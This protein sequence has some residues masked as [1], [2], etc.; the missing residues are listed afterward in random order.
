MPIYTCPMHPQV[1]QNKPGFCPICGMSLESAG[2]E[3]NFELKDMTRRFW[4]AVLLTIPIFVL[5]MVT[6]LRVYGLIQLALATPVVFYC[7]SFFFR[8]GIKS[9][10]MFTLI[11]L[12]VLVAYI[13]SAVAVLFPG[14]FPDSFRQGG[15]G[16]YFEAAAVITVLVILGQILE[17]RARAKTS[18]AIKDLL[19]LSPEMATV[20]VDRSEKKVALA[21]VKVGDILRVRPG[22]KVPVDGKIVEGSSVVDESMI[23]GESLPVEKEMGAKVTGATLNG[24]GSFLMRADKVGN[25]TLLA[26]IVQMVSEAQGSRAPIQKLVDKIASWFVPIIILVALITFVVWWM[27]GPSFAY[28]LI[29]A[30]SVLIIACPCALGLATPM[31]IMVG[32]GKG[33]GMGILIK[34]AEA[35][36]QMA[37][38][39][40]VVV[41][42]TGTLTEGKVRLNQ[43]FAE[44]P[45]SENELLELVASLEQVSEHPLS[46]AIV[47]KAKERGLTLQKT[48]NFKSFTGKGI[49]GEVSGKKLAIGNPKLMQELGI[50]LNQQEV[51]GQ[52]VLYVAINQAPAGFLALSDTVKASSYEAIEQLHAQKIDVVMLTGD[53]QSTA[54]AIGKELKID[55]IESE[56]LP[57]DKNRIVK[58][59]Q[60]QG[61]IVAMAGDGINDA[62]ALAAADIGIAMGTGT[63]VALESAPITLVKGDLRGISRARGL[64]QAVTR[65]IRQNLLFAFIYN[66]LSVP[67]A[68]G[69]LYPFFKILLSPMIASAAMALS[70]V[71]VIWNALRLRRVSL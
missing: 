28:A 42:K 38:A 66:V 48:E 41:D 10:N 2:D 16:L 37:K 46:T 12:G 11:A 1:K 24:S 65:N 61:H 33:A 14:V 36:E 25:D 60:S 26:R 44:A 53:N 58:E 5:A 50:Q 15:I 18:S 34:N 29:N 23:T 62:P 39:D 30:V 21:E 35:F 47:A 69:I 17:L 27:V 70:S 51:E 20:V 68:A 13:Y 40:T 8:R 56:V 22:E 52:T 54:A 4:I 63:D 7:G 71:S 9:L 45:Y 19:K 59:L 57:E 43:I 31:S 49:I 67:I 64:A 32:V 55:R 6:H 3:E